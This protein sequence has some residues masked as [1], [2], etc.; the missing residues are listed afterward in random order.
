[1]TPAIEASATRDEI[2]YSLERAVAISGR[3]ITLGIAG[4]LSGVIVG[5][6][7]GRVAMRISALAAS[8]AVQGL[9]TEA[10]ATIGEI[11]IGGTIAFVVFGGVF[12]GLFGWVVLAAADPWLPKST[13][14]RGPLLSLALVAVAGPVLVDPDNFDFLILDP[15]V[16]NVSMFIAI[17]ALYGVTAVA[18]ASR[19]QRPISRRL[20]SATSWAAPAWVSLGGGLL[21]VLALSSFFSRDFCECRDPAMATGVFF[22]FAFGSAA[23]AWVHECK[24]GRPPQWWLRAVGTLAL[25][26]GVTLGLLRLID[27]IEAIV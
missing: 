3:L 4:M 19:V 23:L 22:A 16:L 11:T 5:G 25:V 7:G 20:G 18:I 2:S 24:T 6:V 8:D 21:S 27:D 9:S 13:L 26:G 14:L 17:P 12:T 10:G 1:M 15:V